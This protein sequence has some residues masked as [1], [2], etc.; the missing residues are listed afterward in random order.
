MK[1]RKQ[2]RKRLLQGILRKMV[3]TSI[4]FM[5]S[6]FTVCPALEEITLQRTETL[7]PANTK[8]LF[9]NQSKPNKKRKIALKVS[10]I[11]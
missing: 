11:D 3:A 1:S 9:K 10:M 2:K 8:H 7:A 6:V 5:T 4:I